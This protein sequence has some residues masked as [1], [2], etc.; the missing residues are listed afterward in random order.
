MFLSVDTTFGAKI[1]WSGATST[2]PDS[3][4]VGYNRKEIVLAPVAGSDKVDCELPGNKAEKGNYGVWLPS[5]LAVLDTQLEV[6][7]PADSR[8]SYSQVIA[9]GQAATDLGQ[10][11][12]LRESKCS[13]ATPV[14]PCVLGKIGD[15]RGIWRL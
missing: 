9:T 5:F 12:K 13:G 15:V 7:S 11:A 1:A 14:H 4:L 6:G 2:I 3:L 8:F 10:N